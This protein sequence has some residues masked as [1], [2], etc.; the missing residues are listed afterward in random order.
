MPPS[1]YQS[2]RAYFRRSHLHSSLFEKTTLD[3]GYRYTATDSLN[4][5]ERDG[6]CSD[7]DFVTNVATIGLRKQF[8]CSAPGP[9]A[10]DIHRAHLQLP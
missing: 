8:W 3:F 10:P 2:E 7:T 9:D 4:F 6:F 1:G 5:T